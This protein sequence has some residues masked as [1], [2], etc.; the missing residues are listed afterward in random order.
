MKKL[1][2][3]AHFYQPT[4]EDLLRGGWRKEDSAAPYVNWNARITA[5]CY[6][7]NIAARLLISRVI[8]GMNEIIIRMLALIAVRRFFGISKVRNRQFIRGS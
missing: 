7:P 1:C 4:R 2:V 6:G 3:H 8:I 5:E